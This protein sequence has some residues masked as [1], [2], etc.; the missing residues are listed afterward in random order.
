MTATGFLDESQDSA[1]FIDLYHPG[2]FNII[3]F[4][5][6]ESRH[7]LP[8]LMEFYQIPEVEI[9]KYVTVKDNEC[10]CQNKSQ[11]SSRYLF[12]LRA[13]QNLGKV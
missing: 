4:N 13:V 5:Q 1:L 2:I 3:Y 11:S 7:C 6:G 10:P 9:G 12:V 8:F